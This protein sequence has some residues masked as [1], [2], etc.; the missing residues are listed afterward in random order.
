MSD[1]HQSSFYDKKIG[2]KLFYAFIYVLNIDQWISIYVK[3][4]LRTLC[5]Y[6]ETCA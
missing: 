3:H 1:E 6:V 5:I 2:E 4:L